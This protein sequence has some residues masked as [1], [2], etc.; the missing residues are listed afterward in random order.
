MTGGLED[1]LK[2]SAFKSSGHKT[3]LQILVTASWI[4]R[5]LD[6]TCAEFGLTFRQYNILRILR[7]VYPKGYSR[8]DIMD[9]MIEPAADVTR[10]L[11]RL[12]EDG[13]AHRYTPSHDKRISLA[14]LT[15]AGLDLINRMD[16]PV[17]EVESWVES[18]ISPEESQ[19][20]GELCE[21]IYAPESV[22]V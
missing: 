4:R 11:D 15:P 5:R 6:A 19:M 2:Q 13:L 8:G 10:I 20:L 9:R 12:V 22:A 7:G 21:R 16:T 17:C 14:A 18:V 1:R 3:I